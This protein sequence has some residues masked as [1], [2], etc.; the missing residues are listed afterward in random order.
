MTSAFRGNQIVG[1]RPRNVV[2]LSGDLQRG[3]LIDALLA[4]P[5]SR[6]V[7]VVQ[8]IAGGYSLIKQLAP[9]LVVIVVGID[10]VAACQLL[11]M[12]K[13]DRDTSAIPVETWMMRREEPEFD[14]IAA[15]TSRDVLV[16]PVAIQMN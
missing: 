5:T 1:P 14:D 9:D 7:V 10:D 3:E 4:D 16:R 15:E 13:M 2:A 12:L 8:S 6:D 11:S